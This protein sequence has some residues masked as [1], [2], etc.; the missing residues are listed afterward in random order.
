MSFNIMIVDDSSA[1]RQVIKKIIGMSGFK[2][3]QCYEAG[4]GLEALSVLSDHWV[5]VILSD[6]NMPRMN[7]LEFLGRVRDHELYRHIPVIMIST[8]GSTERVQEA[9][10]H[11]ARGF[12]KKP[13]LPEE[14]KK[15]LY[16]VVG[17]KEDGA[18]EGNSEDP[19]GSED[20]DF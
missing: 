20:L 13:F 4:H 1:M 15:V 3:D 16:Q 11:G 19:A 17:F 9:F 12:I 5:D 8:E 6:I 7:G 10:D 2:M 18:Y 14:I